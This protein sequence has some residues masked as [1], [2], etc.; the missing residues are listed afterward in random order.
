MLEG[1]HTGTNYLLKEMVYIV[2]RKHRIR[3]RIIGFILAGIL[4]GFVLLLFNLNIFLLILVFLIHLIGMSLIRW[5]FF[6]EAEH[7]VG[8]YY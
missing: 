7:V 5:L 8:L 6:A 2:G 1:P 3:L 4:P